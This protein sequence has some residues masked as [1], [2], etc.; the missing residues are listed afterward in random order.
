MNSMD[1]SRLC[2]HHVAAVVLRLCAFLVLLATASTGHA[3]ELKEAT[4]MTQWSPQAQ[5]AGIYAASDLGFYANHGVDLRVVHGGPNA[6]SSQKLSTGEV[7]FATLFLTTAVKLA[8]QGDNVVNLAQLV[9]RSSLLLVAKKS[10]GVL[11][12]KDLMGR[13]IS[14]WGPEFFLQIDEFLGKHGLHVEVFPQSGTVNLFLRDGVYAASA[15]LYNEYH[16]ILNSGLDAD[17]LAVFHM[18]DFGHNYPE[19][20]VYC[21]KS[22]WERDPE[23]ACAVAQATLEGWR[24]VFDNPDAALKMVMRRVNAAN[25]PT[26]L[27][28][29][30]WML[31]HIKEVIL[32]KEGE[33]FGSLDRKAY[34]GVARSMQA[35]KLI[36]AYPAYEEFHAQCRK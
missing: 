6:S 25:L 24:W 34:D 5:F 35:A 15:M 10:R 1:S 19:D 21:L 11:A 17:E 23:M 12:P 13:A 9:Q 2:P 29:Q 4:L 22:T 18:A 30:R 26:N 36:S 27:E 31:T 8:S 16:T 33:T 7:D 3:F 28:H 32:P 20:G 14:S